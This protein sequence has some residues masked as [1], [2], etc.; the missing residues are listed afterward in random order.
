MPWLIIRFQIIFRLIQRF[1]FFVLYFLCAFENLNFRIVKIMFHWLLRKILCMIQADLGSLFVYKN[2]DNL[3]NIFSQLFGLD[4]LKIIEHRGIRIII[5]LELID[6]I[7]FLAK[8]NHNFLGWLNHLFILYLIF[9]AFR[10]LVGHLYFL[11]FCL[12]SNFFSL[13][14]LLITF[15]EK[16][17]IFK[18]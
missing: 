5:A 13:L 3:S 17:H 7:S 9:I 2:F 18:H 16:I 1:I 11:R 4:V 10:I 6:P 8:I 15:F 12:I 14:M